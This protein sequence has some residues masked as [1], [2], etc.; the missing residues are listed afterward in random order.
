MTMARFD[1]TEIESQAL[2]A[3]IKA[4]CSCVAEIVKYDQKAGLSIRE[5]GTCALHRA[6]ESPRF[7]GRLLFE[8]RDRDRLKAEE[9]RDDDWS[10]N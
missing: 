1:E 10:D 8:R 4:H 9:F 6:L 2:A 5:S 7:L 3:V